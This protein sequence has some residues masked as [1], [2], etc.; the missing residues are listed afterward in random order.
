MRVVICVVLALAAASPL[1]AQQTAAGQPA[2]A[3]A[4]S[5][6]LIRSTWSA[7]TMPSPVVLKSRKIMCPDCSPPMFASISTIFSIT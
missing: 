7:E 6:S 4:P 5:R 1:D 3:G 2:S